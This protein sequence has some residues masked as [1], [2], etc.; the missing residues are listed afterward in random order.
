MPYSEDI[1]QLNSIDDIIN[2]CHNALPIEFKGKPWTHLEL[3]H[4][5]NLLASEVALNCYM[6]AYG[7]MHAT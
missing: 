7:D 2:Y 1:R 3:Q 5:V 6:S 4:G